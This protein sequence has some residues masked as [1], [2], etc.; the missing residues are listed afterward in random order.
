MDIPKNSKPTVHAHTRKIKEFRCKSS[1][2]GP[3]LRAR[4][5]R[6]RKIKEFRCKYL[7]EAIEEPDVI[8][9][10]GAIVRNVN[11]LG[12]EKGYVVS[13]QRAIPDD[14]QDMRGKPK[15]NTISASA[16]KYGTR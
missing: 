12:L 16:I 9:N 8:R 5:A 15:L 13:A 1:R 14:W 3:Y 11:V 10:I 2:M 6:T 7:I 4:D